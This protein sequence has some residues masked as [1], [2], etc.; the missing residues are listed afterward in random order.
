MVEKTLHPP[1][2]R[3]VAEAF[4]TLIKKRSM[5]TKLKALFRRNRGNTTLE[6]Y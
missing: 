4:G 3:E 6:H 5:A 2:F 1:T